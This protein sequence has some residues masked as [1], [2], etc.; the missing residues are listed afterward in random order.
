MEHM[1]GEI[2]VDSTRG[3]TYAQGEM[4]TDEAYAPVKLQVEAA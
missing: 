1:P 3:R 4:E 2:G